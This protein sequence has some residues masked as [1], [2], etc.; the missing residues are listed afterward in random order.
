MSG[1]F[2]VLVVIAMLATLGVLLT[3]VIGMATGS[4]FYQRNANKLM[5]TR[6]ILQA[7]ALAFFA[8]LLLVVGRG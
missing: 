2:V 4:T 6:V 7:I 5:R 8:I 3:G 1:F